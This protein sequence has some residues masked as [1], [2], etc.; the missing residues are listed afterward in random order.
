MMAPSHKTEPMLTDHQWGLVGFI[1]WRLFDRKYSGMVR[2]CRP[3]K[4]LEFDFC[5]EKCLIFQSA[6]KIGNFPWKVLENYYL[7]AWKIMAPENWSVFVFFMHF[8]QFILINNGDSVI[9]SSNL[10]SLLIRWSLLIRGSVFPTWGILS[11]INNG[12]SVI[13]SSDLPSL[14]IRWSLLIRGSVF[15]TWGKLSLQWHHNGCD[16]ISNHQPHDCLLNRL[17]R[18]RWKQGWVSSGRNLFLPGHPEESGRNLFL[19]VL[20]GQNWKK[21]DK[22]GKN[23][24]R[25]QKCWKS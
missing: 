6:L 4:V 15:P 16:G 17:F 24:E 23:C 2:M 20:S 10:L 12:D 14:L 13:S 21:L 3:W 19:P 5:L 18:N 7:W 8:A 11:Y 9:S 22:T 25:C 1:T